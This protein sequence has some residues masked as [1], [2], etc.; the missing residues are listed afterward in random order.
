MLDTVAYRQA[1]EHVLSLIIILL[2]FSLRGKIP[3]NIE[4]VLLLLQPHASTLGDM[5]KCEYT[6]A[7]WFRGLTSG[8]LKVQF[9]K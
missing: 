6:V 4:V 8:H 7:V 3:S 1:D 9:V 5:P 2:F